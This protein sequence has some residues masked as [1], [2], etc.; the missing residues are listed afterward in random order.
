MRRWEDVLA[1]EAIDGPAHASPGRN[2]PPPT[3]KR[4]STTGTKG[5]C[6]DEAGWRGLSAEWRRSSSMRPPADQRCALRRSRRARRSQ[7][8]KEG[9]ASV[10]PRFRGGLPKPAIGPRKLRRTRLHSIGCGTML[11]RIFAEQAQGT[12]S[13]ASGGPSS[14]ERPPQDL[15]PVSRWQ[16]CLLY[17][18]RSFSLFALSLWRQ[19]SLYRR[20]SS[21]RW[22]AFCTAF[23]FFSCTRSK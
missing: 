18:I 9:P 16:W 12:V 6:D 3:Y 23:F 13:A 14:S 1:D 17:R 21:S 10:S 4:G 2:T 19:G 20:A 5:K 7:F 8:S 11:E 15:P 22:F